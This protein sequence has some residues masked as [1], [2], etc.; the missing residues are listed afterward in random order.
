MKS[1]SLVV[2]CYNEADNL[3]SLRRRFVEIV[4][5]R[6][7]LEIVLVDNGS[8]DRTPALMWDLFGADEWATVVEVPQ[9]I[10][11]G[12]GIMSGLRRA[13]GEL[14]G[15]TH[16]D[17][18]TDPADALRAAAVVEAAGED[19]IVVKGKREGRPIADEA[20]TF[21]M[22]IV[23]RL[24]LGVELDDINGQPKLFTR[25][26]FERH[27]LD[28][29]PDDF[30]LDLFALLQARLNGI[31]IEHVPVVFAPR[32]HGEAKGGGSLKTRVRLVKRTL[33]YIME[34]RRKFHAPSEQVEH[35]D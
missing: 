12:H 17:L 31:P 24:A 4:G 27:L 1:L 30:S 2:P 29:A 7:R 21:G 8:T 19:D 26:F 16:A 34:T 25:R 3:E 28:H 35:H 33:S 14:L 11:Y 32:L 6:E 9:N 10:G 13:S 18:Q 22:Q 20:F 5:Q 15:W 23:A